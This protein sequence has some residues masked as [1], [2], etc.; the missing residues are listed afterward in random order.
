LTIFNET[1]NDLTFRGE[2]NRHL[3]QF[4]IHLSGVIDTEH[5]LYQDA[6]QSYIGG[7]GIQ[8]AFTSFFPATQ[9]RVGVNI[10]LQP[11]LLSQFFATLTGELLPELQPLTQGDN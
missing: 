4:M 11:H 2:E 5:S 10:H 3:V 6:N 9:P 7:S 8:P 1:P